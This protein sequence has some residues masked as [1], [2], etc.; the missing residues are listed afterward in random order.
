ME[1]GQAAGAFGINVAHIMRLCLGL[2]RKGPTALLDNGQNQLTRLEAANNLK[3]GLAM[4]QQ[5]GGIIGNMESAIRLKQTAEQLIITEKEMADASKDTD[6][7]VYSEGDILHDQII[8]PSTISEAS[9]PI[10]ALAE[11][12]QLLG[13]IKFDMVEQVEIAIRRLE[14]STMQAAEHQGLVEALNVVVELCESLQTRGGVLKTLREA[15]RYKTILT[16]IARL[17]QSLVKEEN[18]KADQDTSM[19]SDEGNEQQ[20]LAKRPRE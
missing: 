17:V 1:T 8:P 20:R 14:Q 5:K 18:D 3:N 19:V 16:H 7:V 4:I 13:Y 10:R 9:T 11:S 15:T 2:L 12:A 6:A